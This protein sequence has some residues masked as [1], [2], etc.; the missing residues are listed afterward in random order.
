MII[1]RALSAIEP[2]V[3]MA[4]PLLGAR[5]RIIALK[6]GVPAKGSGEALRIAAANGSLGTA[7]SL[8]RHSYTISRSYVR[9]VDLLVL[10]PF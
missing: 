10:E 3:R 8:R 1:S 5:G 7:L 2:F 6:G 9:T 4:V